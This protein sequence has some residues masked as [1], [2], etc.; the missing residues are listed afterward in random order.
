MLCML[1][2][3][4]GCAAFAG[5]GCR[6]ARDPAELV[7]VRAAHDSDATMSAAA[8]LDQQRAI[9]ARRLL[10]FARLQHLAAC[11]VLSSA[12]DYRLASTIAQSAPVS[13]S[14]LRSAYAWA[15][16]AVARDTSSLAGWQALA[17]TWDKWQ[18]SRGAPQWFGTQVSC[19]VGL[20]RCRLAPIDS[21][22]VSD[23]QR[24]QMGLRTLAQMRLAAD[25]LN[26]QLRR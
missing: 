12:S 15:R 10:R 16:E 17:T 1:S 13:D 18:V 7:R 3:I 14:T 4:S 26:Q 8:R 5:R 24:L 23:G 20:G 11:G 6:D 22:R 9:D 19:P 2:A 21:T 25:T